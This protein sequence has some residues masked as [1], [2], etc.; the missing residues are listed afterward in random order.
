MKLTLGS[1]KLIHAEFISR[2]G[3]CV[4]NMVYPACV[5]VPKLVSRK[6]VSGVFPLHC[7][8]DLIDLRISWVHAFGQKQ[9]LGK[10]IGLSS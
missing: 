10:K 7:R 5:S 4:P 3:S 9:P 1:N 2:Y 8:P 6:V